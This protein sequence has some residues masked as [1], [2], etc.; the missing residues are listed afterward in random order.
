VASGEWL[1]R[2]AVTDSD[3]RVGEWR[4]ERRLGVA[5]NA[6]EWRVVWRQIGVSEWRV[7]GRDE[8]LLSASGRESRV[9]VSGGEWRVASGDRD[10]EWRAVVTDAGEWRVPVVSS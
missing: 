1:R 4:V 7:A 5:A 10:S 2:G 9:L 3:V 6:S 8:W